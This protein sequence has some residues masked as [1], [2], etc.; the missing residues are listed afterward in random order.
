MKN[1]QQK[2]IS[3]QTELKIMIK[4]AFHNQSN[5]GSRNRWGNMRIKEMLN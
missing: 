3:E 2:F 5:V 1:T 4:N